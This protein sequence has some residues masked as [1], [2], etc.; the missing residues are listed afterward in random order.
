M[1]TCLEVPERSPTVRSVAV[2]SGGVPLMERVMA[3]LMQCLQRDAELRS[4]EF[5]G[6]PYYRI[7]LGF[8][9]DM[10]QAPALDEQ[11]FGLLNTIATALLSAQPLQTPGF[12]FPWLELI[13]HRSVSDWLSPARESAPRAL[14][15]PSY[16]SKILHH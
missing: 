8:I 13:S 12:A 6:R 5:N 10:G 7:I 1:M 4:D 9:Q 15:I 11:A 16:A 14:L 2:H 3:S